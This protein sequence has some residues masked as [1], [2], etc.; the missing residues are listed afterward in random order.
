[1]ELRCNYNDLLSLPVL[2]EN[3]QILECR[4][5]KLNFLPTLPE[6]LSTLDCSC[7]YIKNLPSLPVNLKRLVCYYNT[8]LTSLPTLPESLISLDIYRNSFNCLPLLP[9]NL[10]NLQFFDSPLFK[11]IN[12]SDIN[13]VKK[14]LHI[15]HKFRDRF[16]ALKFKRPFRKLLWEKVRAPKLEKMYHPKNLEDL[17]MDVDDDDEEKFHKIIDNWIGN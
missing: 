2:P 7:N 13:I 16:H 11:I 10:V 15:L 5:I 4:A 14:K 17:L 1:V 6:N 3:L 9:D 12:S 8:L